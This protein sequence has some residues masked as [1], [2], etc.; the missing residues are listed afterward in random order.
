MVVVVVVVGLDSSMVFWEESMFSD[1]GVRGRL[2]TQR[3]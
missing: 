2:P 3:P 1:R